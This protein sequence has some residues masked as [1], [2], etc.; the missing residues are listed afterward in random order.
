MF[1]NWNKKKPYKKFALGE[2]LIRKARLLELAGNPARIRI[3]CFMF[4]YK[5]ACVSD[6]AESLDM[7]LPGISHHLQIM[8]DNGFFAT[9]RMGQNICYILVENDFMTQLKKVICDV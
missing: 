6:I 8:K 5:K 1:W 2:E 7:T 3:L 9:E 4:E